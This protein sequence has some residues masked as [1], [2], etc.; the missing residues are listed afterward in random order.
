MIRERGVKKFFVF[1][2]KLQKFPIIILMKHLRKIMWGFSRPREA[3]LMKRTSFR[4][5]ILI[6]TMFMFSLKHQSVKESLLSL[7]FLT[8]RPLPHWRDEHVCHII[9]ADIKRSGRTCLQPIHYPLYHRKSICFHPT[10]ACVKQSYPQKKRL[11]KLPS[12]S[13]T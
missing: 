5:W 8:L 10:P 6:F 9:S 1:F 2:D 7:I 13:Q 12:I 3:K 11:K 4:S